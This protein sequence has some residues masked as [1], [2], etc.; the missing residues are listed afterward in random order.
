MGVNVRTLIDD[1]MSKGIYTVNW[2]SMDDMGN[3]VPPGVYFYQLKIG[4]EFKRIGKRIV[5]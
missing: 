4:D 2:D 3:K 5:Q 1:A